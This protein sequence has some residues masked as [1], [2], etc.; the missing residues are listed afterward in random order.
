MLFGKKEV[1]A[2]KGMSCGHCEQAVEQG[3]AGL[4]GITKVKADHGK[5]QVTVYY[6]GDPPVKEDLARTITELGYEVA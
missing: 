5:G 1:L 6:K 4:A 3:L 2:V